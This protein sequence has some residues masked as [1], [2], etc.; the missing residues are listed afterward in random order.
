V[1]RSEA[2]AAADL[3]DRVDTPLLR[4]IET[5]GRATGARRGR[6]LGFCRRI[7]VPRVVG[8]AGATACTVGFTSGGERIH[9][10]R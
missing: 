1:H 5:R 9:L 6:D 3:R 2:K 10:R 8:T 7:A 4:R